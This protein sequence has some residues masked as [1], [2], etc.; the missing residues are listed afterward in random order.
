M[1]LL[2]PVRSGCR[3][4]IRKSMYRISRVKPKVAVF[5]IDVSCIDA[6]LW[7]NGKSLPGSV[8]IMLISQYLSGS[9][10]NTYNAHFIVSFSIHGSCWN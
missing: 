5:N 9:V 8:H 1:Y 2:L 6:S 7:K 10:H 3:N 4:A